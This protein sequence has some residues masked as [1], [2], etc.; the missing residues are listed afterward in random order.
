M[1]SGREGPSGL[2]GQF[3]EL[4]DGVL[5]LKMKRIGEV[6]R[7]PPSIISSRTETIL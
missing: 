5:T 6:E 7:K 3:K 1:T 2:V 4:V